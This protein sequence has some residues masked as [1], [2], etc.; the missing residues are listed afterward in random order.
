VKNETAEFVKFFCHALLFCYYNAV[1]HII[2]CVCVCVC[3]YIYIYIYI[4]FFFSSVSLRFPNDV[5]DCGS[6]GCDSYKTVQ[7][8]QRGK[9]SL[10]LSANNLLYWSTAN[11][12]LPPT[13]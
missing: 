2:V 5:S 4:F 10:S 9:L 6:P 13:L 11:C 8:Q 12:F 1:F 3:V 7:L